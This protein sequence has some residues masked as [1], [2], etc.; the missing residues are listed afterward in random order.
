MPHFV[1]PGNPRKKDEKIRKKVLT[2][3][4][5]SVILAKRSTS[6]REVPEP[7]K[8]NLRRGEKTS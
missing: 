5:R 3:G 4:S 1:V 8:N 2:K 6:G 7:A